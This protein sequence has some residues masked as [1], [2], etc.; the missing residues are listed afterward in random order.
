MKNIDRLEDMRLVV[1][2]DF[3]VMDVECIED[4]DTVILKN[5]EKIQPLDELR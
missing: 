5:V 2:P 1:A 4:G 3:I